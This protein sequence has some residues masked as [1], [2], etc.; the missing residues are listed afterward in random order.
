[1]NNH[2]DFVKSMKIID[3]VIVDN[4][5]EVEAYCGMK[6]EKKFSS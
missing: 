5:P 1:M 3:D 2:E 6:Y 4:R